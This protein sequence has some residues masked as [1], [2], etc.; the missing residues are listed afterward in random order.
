MK[1]NKIF[2]V[3]LAAL[4][5][6]GFNAC[7]KQNNPDEPGKEGD[8]T[9]DKTSLNLEVEEEETITATIAVSFE[10]SNPQVATVTPANDGKSAKVKAIAEGS[11]VITAKSQGGQAKTCIV[12]VKEK[13]GEGG[14]TVQLKGSQVWPIALDGTTAD[15]NA[16]KIV[17]DFRPNDVDQFLYVWENGTVYE[18]GEGKGLN[19]HGNTDG[20]T[21]LKVTNL[22]WAGAGFCLTENGNGWQAAEALRAAI[23]A[24]PDQYF[25]HMAMKSTD[26]YSHCFYMFG[27]EATKFVIGS[28]SVYD[29]PVYKDFT[30]DGSWAEFDIP[31]SSYAAALANVT[32]AAGVNVFVVLT[33]GVQGAE[34]NL[35]AVY[36]YKK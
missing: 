15:A 24:N 14:E 33:E 32:C 9:L 8:L 36:F 7:N 18:A 28:K 4:T 5:L 17:A 29:G 3:A 10:S 30:R 25:L 31:M 20:Y 34:L 13:G 26:N 35:D 22:G 16:S 21:A 6:V 27:S 23:V 1:A 2:A 12:A 19:F 11:A